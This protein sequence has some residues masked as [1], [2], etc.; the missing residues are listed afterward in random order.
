MYDDSK[1]RK[2]QAYNLAVQSALAVGKGD[3]TEYVVQQF[4]K[5]Y[6]FA[7]ILQKAKP[8]ELASAL[9]N[10]RVMEL[11]AKLDEELNK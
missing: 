11:L 5:H 10:P 6:Q 1:V 3:D 2:G 8:E 4:L 9:Q 7:D